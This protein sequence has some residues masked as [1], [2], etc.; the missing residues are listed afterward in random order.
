MTEAPRART[1]VEAVDVALPPV[2]EP[3]LPALTKR[4]QA[5]L[6][7]LE[8]SLDLSVGRPAPRMRV[9]P[10][11]P[12]HAVDDPAAIAE[13]HEQ[14]SVLRSQ[15]ETAFDEV[16]ARIS[17]A[18]QRAAAAEARADA[19]DSRAQVASARAA[20]VLYAVDELSAELTRLADGGHVDVQGLRGAVERLR[21]RLQPTA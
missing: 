4:L 16:D 2:A 20:N 19:A 6:E 13:L 14:L 1:P 21:A 17:A 18:D 10:P 8:S 5:R 7:A 11:P 3:P 15:L 12:T 9:A